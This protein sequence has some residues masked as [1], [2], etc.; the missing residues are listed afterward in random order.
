MGIRRA[1]S[2]GVHTTHVQHVLTAVAITL[3][4]MDAVLTQT[5]CDQTRH[6]HFIRL[7]VH[8]SWQRQAAA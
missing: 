5:P 7:A 1:R 2:D 4:R 8:P 3:V 6:S